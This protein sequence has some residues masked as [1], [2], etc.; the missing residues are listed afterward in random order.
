MSKQ[1]KQIKYDIPF[2]APAGKCK[3]CRAYIRWIFTKNGKRMP[4][5]P[6]GTPHFATCPKAQQFQ[7]QP[8]KKSQARGDGQQNLF[9]G[10]A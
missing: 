6:D 5:D 1:I 10:G 9:E 4:V 3:G 8:K 7:K 2:N